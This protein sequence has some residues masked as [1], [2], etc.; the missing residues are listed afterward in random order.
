MQL[1]KNWRE[2]TL[3]AIYAQKRGVDAT[4]KELKEWKR[5]LRTRLSSKMQLRKNWRVTMPMLN[6]LNSFIQMQ[7][8][9]N[10]RNECFPYTGS[11]PWKRMQLRK[12]WR[13]GDRQGFEEAR[14]VIRM[15]LRK[16]WRVD[17]GGRDY[18][19]TVFIRCNSE[20]IE[21]NIEPRQP[22]A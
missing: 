18:Y 2:E 14:Q 22:P 7:L 5:Q 21:G 15:Q 11:L 4:Q 9:K 10:W 3:A 8:R 12:N 13:Y 17:I 1:R 16:N 6:I 19:V 20:R